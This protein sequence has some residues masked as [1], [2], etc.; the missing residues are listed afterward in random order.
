MTNQVQGEILYAGLS[1]TDLGSV[2][3]PW[4]PVRGDNG[5]FG[6]EVMQVN[7]VTLTWSVQTRT[8]ESDAVTAMMADQTIATIGVETAESTTDAKELVR[9]KFSTGGTANTGEFVVFRAL[10]PSWQVDR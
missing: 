4:M 5:T 1:G 2:Y 7:R 3:T 9:Y 8:R 6:V 10:Q